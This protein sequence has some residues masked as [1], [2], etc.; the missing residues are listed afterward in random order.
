MYICPDLTGII[1]QDFV[2]NIKENQEPQHLTS[3]EYEV[4]QLVTEGLSTK[5]IA[6]NLHL[7]IKTIETHRMH[8]MEKVN[9]TSVAALTKYAIREG[10]TSL[11]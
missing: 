2:Q 3:R 4:L 5:E 8:I 11:E 10:I 9:V 6:E 7:S 1:V